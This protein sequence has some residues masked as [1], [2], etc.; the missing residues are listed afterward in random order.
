M[1]GNSVETKRLGTSRRTAALVSGVALLLM[2]I[3]AAVANF[4]V[5]EGAIVS[6]DAAAT[7][8]NIAGAPTRFRLGATGFLLVALL[9][10]IV[11]WGLYELFRRE[12]PGLS[13]LGGW[14]R[15]AYAAIFAVAIAGLFT[16][17]RTAPT[18]AAATLLQVQRFNDGWTAGLLIFGGHLIVVGILAWRSSFV[19]WIF[20]LLLLVAGAGYLVDSLAALVNP[21]YSL[22]LALYTFVGEV[23]FIFWLLIRGARLL[24]Y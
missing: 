5:L 20:G 6:S 3:V 16:A 10:V 18:D 22:E 13:L 1:S 21:S 17:A 11:A 2:A 19:H 9:D 8:A 12:Q 7:A 23:L 14:L 24:D 15:L 4:A